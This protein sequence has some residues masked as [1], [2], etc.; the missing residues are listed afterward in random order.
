MV[1]HCLQLRILHASVATRE[2]IGGLTESVGRAESTIVHALHALQIAD[3]GGTPT[4]YWLPRASDEL[5]YPL[6]SL[7]H[8]EVSSLSSIDA[9][10]KRGGAISS[11]ADAELSS[12]RTHF[13]CSASELISL[14]GRLLIMGAPQDHTKVVPEFVQNLYMLS[15]SLILF[16]CQPLLGALSG[17]ALL[18]CTLWNSSASAEYH[19]KSAR[20]HISLVL[21][22]HTSY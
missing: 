10:S 18:R 13:P 14:S 7:W 2:L 3:L 4:S 19:G 17:K 12:G 15:S 21:Q 22:S 8:C 9:S 5:G 16:V 1:P 20:A 11:P 6:A